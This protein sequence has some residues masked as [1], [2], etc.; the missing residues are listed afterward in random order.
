M[1]Q[2][3]CQKSTA[4]NGQEPASFRLSCDE[5]IQSDDINREKLWSLSAFKLTNNLKEKR[6]L[7]IESTPRLKHY[8]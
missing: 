1:N 5:E 8:L 7:M 6:C 4:A 2:E 3:D